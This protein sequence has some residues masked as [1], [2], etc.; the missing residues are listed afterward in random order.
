MIHYREVSHCSP[1]YESAVVF[2][3]RLLREPLGLRLLPAELATESAAL[4][5]IAEDGDEI[6]GYLQLWPTDDGWLHMK[7]VAV[8]ELH[9]GRG[10]GRELVGFAERLAQNTQG[11]V[12]HARETVVG[13]YETLGYL[14]EGERFE[15]VGIPHFRMRKFLAS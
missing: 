5:T 2:R 8:V 14:R 13:F 3:Q 1:E 15:E 4:H 7:Q 11:I 9:Q 6:V 10:I 12:L